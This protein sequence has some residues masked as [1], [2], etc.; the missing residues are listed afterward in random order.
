MMMRKKTKKKRFDPI[1]DSFRHPLS[2]FG[3]LILVRLTVVLLLLLSLA[4]ANIVP[5]AALGAQ[6]PSGSHAHDFVIFANVFNEKGFSLF[7]ARVRVRREEEKKFRWDATSDHSGELAIRV[8]QNAQYELTIE[9]RGFKTQAR[10]IDATQGN[11]ADLTF[12]ME[13]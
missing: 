12:R 5:M 4:V 13:P 11:R 7:G 3:H 1:F 6:N 10:K 9:A 2:P 8:P